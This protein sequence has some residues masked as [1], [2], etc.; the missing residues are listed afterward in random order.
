MARHYQSYLGSNSKSMENTVNRMGTL[1]DRMVVAETLIQTMWTLLQ[2]Q[3]V[4]KDQLITTMKKTHEIRK[5]KSGVTVEHA[6]PQCGKNM[7]VSVT[8]PYLAKCMYCTTEVTIDPYE[9]Y[10]KEESTEETKAP[11]QEVY[12]LIKDLNL[13]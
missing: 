8:T 12:D 11:A 10:E 2:E 4:T 7:L 13:E 9:I 6:C 1:E 3:G 5:K